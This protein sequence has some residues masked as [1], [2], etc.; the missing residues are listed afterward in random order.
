LAD[1]ARRTLD[2]RRDDRV[3][4][5]HAGPLDGLGPAAR[6]CL[7]A[8]IVAGTEPCPSPGDVASEADRIVAEGLSAVALHA[9]G[10]L[11]DHRDQAY[12]ATFRSVA[13]TTQMR[14]M[15]ADAAAAPALAALERAGVPAVVV[16][17]PATARLHPPG[18][19][20][21]YGDVDLVVD[22]G[23]FTR[24][25]ACAEGLGFATSTRAVP[26]WG[27]FDRRCREGVNLHSAAGGNLDVHHHVPPW[28]LG[29]SV[30]AADIILRSEPAELCGTPVRF[31]AAGDLL[32]VSA[33]H[34]LN[35]LW[36][37][38][39][40]L[41][42]WRDVLVLLHRLGPEG[43][44]AA[45]AGAR[46]GW[47]HDLMAVE[48]ARAVPEA[49]I[50]HPRVVAAPPPAARFRMA[51]LGWSGQTAWTRLRL[52]WVSRL[53]PANGVAFLAGTLVPSPAYIRGRHGSYGTYWRRGLTEAVATAHGADHRMTTVDDYAGGAPTGGVRRRSAG[54]RNRW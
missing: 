21:S 48:L 46:L 10:H 19:P 26:P 30:R 54:E 31:A 24:A 18:W 11:P 6:W 29:R 52:A 1:H 35:D 44:Q 8:G 39:A 2:H 53:P 16:K 36:K 42:S 17:G 45:F 4:N 23:D 12:C 22:P 38:K 34:V 49:G 20:R 47:L 43:S 7:T 51:A 5:R 15:A 14:G 27:W 28:S 41:A 50:E 3:T 9:F 25:L 37:G 33:L 40:G 32:L 13:L